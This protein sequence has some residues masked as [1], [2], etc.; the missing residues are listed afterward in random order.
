[1]NHSLKSFKRSVVLFVAVMPIIASAQT[2]EDTVSWLTAELSNC[3]SSVTVGTNAWSVDAGDLKVGKAGLIVKSSFNRAT[4][5]FGKIKSLS[6]LRYN[7]KGG[8]VVIAA[9]DVSSSHRAFGSD[10]DENQGPSETLWLDVYPSCAPR[11]EKLRKAIAHI[12]ELNGAK[13]AADDLF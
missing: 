8:R 10:K 12:A 9:S 3:V 13:P 4:L 2:I 5:D 11:L 7:E 1:M 6:V